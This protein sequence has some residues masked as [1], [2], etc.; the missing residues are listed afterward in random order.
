SRDKGRGEAALLPYH[1]YTRYHVHIR[2]L[3]ARIIP[4]QKYSTAVVHHE[5]RRRAWW[6][7]GGQ[8]SECPWCWS[9]S[10]KRDAN[11]FRHGQDRTGPGR[12]GSPKGEGGKDDNMSYVLARTIRSNLHQEAAKLIGS[13]GMGNQCKRGQCFARALQVFRG[14]G[15]DRIPTE[16]VLAPLRH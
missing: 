3:A 5:Q 7:R 13:T 12:A 15:M 10:D 2:A 6:R 4:V 16:V 9:S 14:K 1:R 11:R 8:G